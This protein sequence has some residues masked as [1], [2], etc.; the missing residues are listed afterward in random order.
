MTARATQFVGPLT[1]Q[2]LTG[3]PVFHD[4]FDPGQESEIGHIQIADAPG[5]GAPGSGNLPLGEWIARSRELGYEGYVGLE[6]K[7]PADSAF[8]WAIRE[9]ASR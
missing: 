7:E 5:R 8:S 4:L 1:F 2:T 6:Y 3:R 9:H